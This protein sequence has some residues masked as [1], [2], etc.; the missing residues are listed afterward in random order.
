MKKKVPAMGS[1]AWLASLKYHVPLLISVHASLLNIA[2][3]CLELRLP[4]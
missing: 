2:Y 3:A 4:I 1:E